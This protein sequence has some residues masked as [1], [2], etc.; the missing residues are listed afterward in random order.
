MALVYFDISQFDI[1][2]RVDNGVYLMKNNRFVEAIVEFDY[3]LRIDPRERWAR[4]NRMTSRLSLGDYS[5]LAEH[6][7]A[8]EIYDWGKPGSSGPSPVIQNLESLPVWCGE[9]CNLLVW[10]NMGFGDA[11]MTLRF[12]SELVER[13]KNVTMVIR[14]E[15]VNLFQ[16]YG[17]TVVSNVS[18]ISN[19]DARLTF[20]NSIFM[21]GHSLQTIPI[22]PYI[23]ANFN[24]TGGKM[25]IAWSGNSRMELNI[26]SFLSRLD[27]HG[28]KLYALQKGQVIDQV[29]SL[30]C[31]DFKETADLM[32]TL[33]HIVTVDTAAAHLACALG[34]PSVHLLLPFVMDWRWWNCDVWYPTIKTYRQETPD[35]WSIP[36]ARLNAAL[37]A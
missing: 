32:M 37:K 12:L 23:K 6:D 19:F 35:D 11:I 3:V 34:H 36:F 31:N 1:A 4:Y 13:C 9:R 33:D 10:H 27:T 20:F 26:H 30:E 18:D 7:C 2:Q 21:M 16:G 17:A 14:P 24:F 28:F 22:D 8:W 15:L 29:V 5:A 25:G